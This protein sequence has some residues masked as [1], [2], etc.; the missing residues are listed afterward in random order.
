NLLVNP[1]RLVLDLF[2]VGGEALPAVAVDD[3]I[4]EKIRS[5]PFDEQTMRLVFDLN[6][7]TGYRIS[8]WPEGGLEVEFNYLLA[9][10]GL[11]IADGLA[12]LW[13]EISAEPEFRLVYLEDPDRLVIDLQNTTLIGSARNIPVEHD[14]IARLRASQHLP[15]TTRIVLDLLKPVAPL[16][17]Q[18]ED[19]RFMLPLFAGSAAEA[20]AFLAELEPAEEQKAVE[21]V[22]KAAAGTGEL[23]GLVIAVDPGHGGSDPGAIGH[24]GTFEKDIALAVSKFLGE[25][26]QKAGAQVVYTRE[27]DVYV[28]IFERPELAIAAQADIYVSVHTNSHIKRGT[29][30]GTETLYRA[31]D[32]ISQLLARSVQDELVKA[33]TLIDRRIWPRDDLAVF[34]GSTIPAILVE[35]GFLDHP[36]EEILL[37]AEGFQRAAAEGIF[38]GVVRFF[39]EIK[40]AGGL[41]Q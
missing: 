18:A 21:P 15:S 28:S 36:E 39:D 14:R 11:E 26:L 27:K 35:V 12:G 20:E 37:K 31:G 30:R 4:V 6:A 24:D 9:D 32:Q 23:A 8:P 33:I 38:H 16:A 5:S 29:A 3:V 41:G 7:S 2:G 17:L 25:L 34:N 19:S 40:E 13:L 22:K 10:L 1:D